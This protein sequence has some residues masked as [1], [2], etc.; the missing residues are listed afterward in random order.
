MRSGRPV[1]GAGRGMLKDILSRLFGRPYV[2]PIDF[3][4]FNGRSAQ[5]VYTDWAAYA[6]IV[7][8]SES[9]DNAEAGRWTERRAVYERIKEVVDPRPV[10]AHFYQ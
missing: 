7:F 1:Y 2:K 8:V 9:R 5:G 4:V 10:A 6:L 3:D